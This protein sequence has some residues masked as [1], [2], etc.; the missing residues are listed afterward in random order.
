MVVWEATVGPPA[1]GS[2]ATLM[3]D[4]VIGTLR[5]SFNYDYLTPLYPSFVPLIPQS[6]TTTTN[7][8]QLTH[9]FSV[10]TL[11]TLRLL[12]TVPSF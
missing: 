11:R 4:D 2:R 3:A 5:P 9:F 6:T 1:P 7:K 10:N 12:Q 8:Q